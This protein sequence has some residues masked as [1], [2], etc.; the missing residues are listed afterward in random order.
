MKHSAIDTALY[1]AKKAGEMLK[2]RVG[3]LQEHE[4]D[5]KDTFDFVTKTDKDAE[6]LIV[7]IIQ[8]RHPGHHFLAEE[9]HR[10]EQGDYRWI[11]DPLDGTTNF[12][13]GVPMYSVSIALQYDRNV[14]LG[15]VYDPNQDECFVAEQGQ[16]AFLNNTRIQVSD[17]KD[18]SRALLAT[19]YPFR[20]KD[21]IDVYLQSF[22][23]FFQDF[24]GI[25][26]AGSAAVDLCYVACGRFDGFWE[27]NLKPWD[28]AAA[29]CII[30][31]AGGRITDFA[32]KD[33]VLDTGNTIAA[34]AHVYDHMANIIQDTFRGVVEQ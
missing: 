15:V 20:S 2:D 31:E 19:G 22:K 7:D 17:V 32:G 33:R 10:A 13:H 11:I 6:K 24:S 12:I 18:P 8:S 25:R 4:I 14:I 29:Q 9:S 28:I 34:N 21:L 23:R 1:A 5:N 16:G 27:L 3:Q 26:R 30:Q